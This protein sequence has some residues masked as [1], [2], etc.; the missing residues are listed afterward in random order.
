MFIQVLLGS[1]MALL[2]GWFVC[3]FWS[4][5]GVAKSPACWG[6][7]IVCLVVMFPVQIPSSV[8]VKFRNKGYKRRVNKPLDHHFSNLKPYYT[9]YIL[10]SGVVCVRNH[11]GIPLIPRKTAKLPP[12]GSSRPVVVGLLVFLRFLPWT[13]PR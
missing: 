1:L 3:K 8:H 13:P 12:F 4:S 2:P 6:L 11:I 5:F 7:G 10:V 9:L